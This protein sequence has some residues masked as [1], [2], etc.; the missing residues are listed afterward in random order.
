MGLVVLRRPTLARTVVG[1]T[2][3]AVPIPAYG[4]R[5]AWFCPCVSWL[6]RP[7]P[8]RVRPVLL[9][10]PRT[11]PALPRHQPLTPLAEIEPIGHLL[12]FL[13]S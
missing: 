12:Y 9:Q 8:P 7:Q 4:R 11:S 13:R 2:V 6:G 10:P 5:G 1:S 3:A